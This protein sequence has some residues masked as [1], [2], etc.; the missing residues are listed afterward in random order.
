MKARMTLASLLVCLAVAGLGWLVTP[1][2]DGETPMTG[3]RPVLLSPVVRDVL[4][5]ADRGENWTDNLADA[6]RLLLDALPIAGGDVTLPGPRPA[7]VDAGGLLAYTDRASR[8]KEIAIAVVKEADTT[9]PPEGLENLHGETL[10]LAQSYAAAAA[11]VQAYLGVPTAEE[12]ARIGSNL[13][14]LAAR[15]K[16]LRRDYQA[17]A[18]KDDNKGSDE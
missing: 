5:Y 1:W 12:A 3:N 17:L 9:R 10:G 16:A 4:R 18:L 8:A 15:R 7:R 13:A 6:E 11:S 14:K 2:V